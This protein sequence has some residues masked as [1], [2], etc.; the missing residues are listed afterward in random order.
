MNASE[1]RQSFL[2]FFREKR[3]T[4]V[5]SA[6]LLPSSPNL[7]FTNAGMN[8]FVPYFLGQ[9]RVPYSPPRVA[10]TQ[11]CIRAGGKHND[12]DDVGFDTYH[13]TF[14]EML[15]N[16]SFGD[17]FKKEAIGW[18]WELLVERWKFPPNRLYATVYQPGMGDPANFDQEAYAC[19]AAL[20]ERAGLDPQI[21][22][23]NGNRKDNFWMMGDTGPCGPCSEVHMDLTVDGDTRG[24]LVNKGS[25]VCIEIWNL[26]FIQFNANADG[27]FLALPA[28]HV[29]TGMGFER[30]AGIMACTDEFKRFDRPI[31]NYES[32]VFRPLFEQIVILNGQIYGRN[33]PRSR[34]NLSDQEKIDV[35]FRVVA[36]HLRALCFAI[37]DG[38][39]PS[40]TDRNYVLRR[41]LRRA[42]MFGRYLGFGSESFLSKLAPTVV[43]IFGSVFPELEARKEKLVSILDSEESLFNHTLDRGLRIFEEEFNNRT[44][45]V[46][47]PE[48]AFRLYDTYGFPIDLTEVL[49]LERGLT[50]DLEAVEKQL[51]QQR[52]R[53]RAAQEKEIIKTIEE[54]VPTEFVG[55]SQDETKARLIELV[56]QDKNELAVVDRS[57][58]YAEMGGQVSDTGTIVFPDGSSAPVL[59][60]TRQG[61]TFYHRLASPVRSNVPTDV[62]LKVDQPRRRMVE[63][64]HTATHLLHWALHEIVGRDVSQKGS[65]VGPERLRFDFNSNSVLPDQLR[66]I[67]QLVNSRIIANETV[68]WVEVPYEQAKNRSDI[69]QFF[70]EKYGADVRVV[71]IGGNPGHLD[72]YSME[73]CGGTHVSRTGQLGLFHIASEGAISAGVRRIEAL[74]GLVAVSYLQD[75]LDQ[76]SVKVD[77]LNRQLLDLKKSIDKERTQSLQREAEQIV[78]RFKLDQKSIVEVVQGANGE[79]LQAIANSLKAKKFAGVAVL[80]GKEADQV[81][82]LAVVD[83]SFTHKVQAGKIVQELTGLLDG[84]G[85]GKPDLARGAGKD[86]SKL[87]LAKARAVE[88]TANI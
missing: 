48:V 57:P 29:D 62:T 27:S 15:G 28:R 14:F 21:H 23:V 43:D 56:K 25:P 83:L 59:A 35:A 68:S 1:I 65:Y 76:R 58:L 34:V 20:F 38:I 30:V 63:A 10:D 39:I 22:V 81:H 53:S 86:S 8:Q 75:Q 66:R 70:G 84:K 5:P 78:E 85:G 80:F 79:Q 74:T 2:D 3:H 37:A 17:Y 18:A 46:F 4:V 69:M 19:W 49:V 51:E 12:L 71:Q 82:V 32:N 31:S 45:N 7:L 42:V 88:L 6:S 41:I 55:F 47:P 73:L 61:R 67:E 44:T 72:G 11:K 87:D 24:A 64:N 52:E 16:W 13:H 77:E 40:N 60:V 9:E 50:L 26:V 36:D 33:L 54:S